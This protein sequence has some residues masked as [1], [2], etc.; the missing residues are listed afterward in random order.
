M[1]NVI[2]INFQTSKRIPPLTD[3]LEKYVYFLYFEYYNFLFIVLLKT[4]VFTT[5][6]YTIK[7]LKTLATSIQF[8]V[9]FYKSA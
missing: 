7:F 5:L 9:R 8:S 2:E 3:K 6:K 1:F 4:I